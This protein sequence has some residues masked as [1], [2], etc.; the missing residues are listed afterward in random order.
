MRP[1]LLAENNWKNLKE[2]RFDLAVLPW[3]ATEA[4]NYHLPYGTD[5]FEA[6]AISAAA[7]KVA[8][9]QGAK[10]IVLPTIPF[11]VNTGQSDIY[12]DINMNPSTQLAIIRDI[13]TVLN[14]QGIKKFLILN[15]HGGND[16]KTILRE[17]GLEFPEMLLMSCNWYQAL[18][19]TLYFDVA[20][21]HADEMETSLIMYL[22]PH[23]VLPLSE[24][25]D[26]NEKK[27]IFTGVS[28]KWAWAERRW[29]SVTEDTGIGNPKKSNAE[30]GERYFNDIAQKVGELMVEIANADLKKLYK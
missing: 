28:E 9:E 11:G 16:F 3:G 30:K 27:S 2:Q 12:L 24:A 19:K 1:Y 5:I 6:E 7:G 23:L 18:D 29:S 22:H 4:H 20:G 26:G 21:D 13:L 25:G 8:W 17:L 15:S 10:V 14:R